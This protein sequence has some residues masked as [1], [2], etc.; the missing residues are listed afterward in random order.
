MPSVR[1]FARKTS[2]SPEHDPS[3]ATTGTRADERGQGMIEYVLI[4]F[5][6][7]IFIVGAFSMSGVAG[8]TTDL[9]SRVESALSLDEEAAPVVVVVDDDDDDD[10]D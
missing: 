8:A 2:P 5:F 7:S 9:A 1:F 3:P 10:D 4:G 6:I